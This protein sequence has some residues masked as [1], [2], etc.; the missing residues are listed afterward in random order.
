[1]E[2]QGR[3]GETGKMIRLF[4]ALLFPEEVKTR[5]GELID[6]LKPHA[7]GIKWV[8]AK[9]I[10]LTL[11]FIG[12][13]PQKKVGPITE[14][15]ESVLAG[16]RRFEGRI[17][18]VGGFPD[19]RHPRVLW[20]GLDGAALAV[21]I[22]GELDRRLVPAGIKAEKRPLSPHLTLGRV[23][24]PGDFSGLAVHIQGLKFDAGTVILDRVALVK[25][26]L[27]PTGPIYE[28]VKLYNLE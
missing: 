18:G 28:V 12:E 21:E 1:M 16:R 15:L 4:I 13:V 22:A 7:R 24:Q 19:L 14:I 3:Q 6:D 9:N 17:V 23:K 8:D 20:V 11:K 26:T 10:H 5:L 25:S 27:T 2:N